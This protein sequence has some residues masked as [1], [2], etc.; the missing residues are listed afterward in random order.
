MLMNVHTTRLEIYHYIHTHN[1]FNVGKNIF[2][3]HIA[4]I[5]YPKRARKLI[6]N[7]T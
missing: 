7:K 1:A 5:P 3:D 6:K 4:L 2:T